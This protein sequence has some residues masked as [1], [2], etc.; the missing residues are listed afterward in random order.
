MW[1]TLKERLRDSERIRW[2][3]R[4]MRMS[5][6]RWKYGLKSVSPTFYLGGKADIASDLK[7][8]D[9]SYIGRDCCICPRVT[10]G[11]FT[12][13]A[14]EVSVQGGD[15]VYDMPGTPICFTGRPE[16]PVTVIED[17]VWVGH[18]AIIMAGVTIGRG[19]VVAAGAV[20]TKSVEPYSIVGG[21]PASKIKMRFDSAESRRVHDRMLS[22]DATRGVLP[23]PR[24]R[25]VSAN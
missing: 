15:H 21:I 22:C 9:Y 2:A 17:D 23:P 11:K 19:A 24:V 7:A 1:A 5:L 12:Y 18:R 20:V 8:G 3:I 4:G 10:I 6:I 14:H 25:G 13:L 16:M